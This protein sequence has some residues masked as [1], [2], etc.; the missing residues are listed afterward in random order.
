MEKLNAT[1]HL[2]LVIDASVKA[3]SNSLTKL[4][5]LSEVDKYYWHFIAS[6]CSHIHL[7]PENLAKLKTYVFIT[8]KLSII[9]NNYYTTCKL[10][11]PSII[12]HIPQEI[13]CVSNADV[14][15]YFKWIIKMQNIMIHWQA[16]F[17][18]QEVNH[19]DI[20]AYV[21]NLD[22]INSFAAAVYADHLVYA[23]SEISK[24][25]KNYSGIYANLSSL[26]IKSSKDYGW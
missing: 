15:D 12:H 9:F 17:M 23:D 8:E 24:L 10:G 21:G 20:V 11:K 14:K 22:S 25:K 5:Q 2:K 19:D 6:C 18:E 26:L 7:N 1:N 13:N 4:P 16:K 3:A